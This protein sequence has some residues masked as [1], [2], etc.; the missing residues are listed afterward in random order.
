MNF[1]QR[2]QNERIKNQLTQDEVA[3]KLSVSRQTI[4]S[5][6]NER[7]YPDIN[8]LI[9]L[10]DF[11]NISLDT[12]LKEDS[13]M[14][15]YLEKN[16]ITKNLKPI[17]VILTFINV[18]FLITLAFVETNFFDNSSLF[19]I[20]I[21]GISNTLALLYLSTFMS[22]IKSKKKCIL[23]NYMKKYKYHS[24]GIIVLIILIG[25][26]VTNYNALAGGLIVGLGSGFIATLISKKS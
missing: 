8:S 3:N 23:F 18:L 9:I 12:L 26:I 17:L 10:S 22:K 2:L 1:G 19:L 4:S 11:Y 7:T 21:M 16:E 24:I 25:L 14:K 20:F 6:E 15:E 5:W 13:G